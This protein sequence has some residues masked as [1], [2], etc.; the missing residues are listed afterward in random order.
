M[1]GLLDGPLAFGGLRGGSL[2]A[3]PGEAD[4]AGRR[5]LVIELD[6]AAYVRDLGVSGR[7][8]VDNGR[9]VGLRLSTSGGPARRGVLRVR[10]RRV[11][12]RVGRATVRTLVAGTELAVPRAVVAA[13]PA[14]GKPRSC[15]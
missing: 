4:E 15:G 10:G 8:V 1:Q 9:I 11:T 2:C 5:S 14:G 12:G 13:S 7:A 3:Y 6:G